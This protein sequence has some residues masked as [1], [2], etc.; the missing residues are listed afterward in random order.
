MPL[1]LSDMIVGLRKEIQLAQAKAV[2]E[3]LKFTVDSVEIEAQVTVS[4]EGS[5]KTGV[6]WKF[7]IFSEA[8][9]EIAGKVGREKVQTIR[10]KLTPEQDS[11]DSVKVKR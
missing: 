3:D 9:A 8:D 2:K 11:G 4:M 7:L 1:E 6:K 10:L 5:G